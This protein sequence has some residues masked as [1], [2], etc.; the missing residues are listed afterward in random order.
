MAYNQLTILTAGMFDHLSSLRSLVLDSNRISSVYSE[1]FANL[2]SLTF[3]S[4]AR[5]I[6][7]ALQRDMFKDLSKLQS[8]S[9]SGNDVHWIEDGAFNGL[10][11]LTFLSLV[12]NNLNSSIFIPNVF[13]NIADTLT[14]L[15]L[16][17]NQIT[18]IY[19]YVFRNFTALKELYIDAHEIVEP[20]SFRGL[21]SLHR[22]LLQNTKWDEINSTVW[23]EIGDTLTQ[24][25]FNFGSVTSMNKNMFLMMPRLSSLGMSYCNIRTIHPEAFN[26]LNDLLTLAL[27]HNRISEEQIKNLENVGSTLKNLYLW[28]NKITAIPKDTFESFVALETLSLTSNQLSQLISGGFR[29]LP[30]LTSLNLINNAIST[31]E[32]GSFEGVSSLKI[33][34]LRTNYITAILPG[35]F[36]G[37]N[38]LQKLD[39][40]SN[41]ITEEELR[42]LQ[43]VKLTLRFLYMNSNRITAIPIDTFKGFNALEQLDLSD[44]QISQL[45]SGAFQGLSSMTGIEL[46]SN[47][48]TSLEWTAFN[49]NWSEP[50]GKYLNYTSLQIH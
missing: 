7:K 34:Y 31:M 39:L 12:N 28:N 30:S 42:N 49:L 46:N 11:S 48:L 32:R 9:F 1:A 5:N 47:L 18:V 38:A 20:Y 24:F 25:S 41:M 10:H 50:Q 17:Q 26:G 3:L 27:Q 40:G 22:L 13:T 44:N 36:N 19:N 21:D 16:E 6:F 4:L 43:S 37:L 35:T 33:L 23:S 29:G 2:T 15:G 8:L 14:V 45:T